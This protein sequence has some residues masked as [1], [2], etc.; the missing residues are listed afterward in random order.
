MTRPAWAC[1]N[2]L[3]FHFRA[4]ITA[5]H[6][7]TRNN[8]AT[9]CEAVARRELAARVFRARL[10]ADNL[11]GAD[12]VLT[13]RAGVAVRTR[14]SQRVGA[15]SRRDTRLPKNCSRQ[16]K[17][18]RSWL[19]VIACPLIGALLPEENWLSSSDRVGEP[20]TIRWPESAKCR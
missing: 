20:G 12:Y 14:F 18:M 19:S 16:A 7:T 11:A 5:A 1:N 3:R 2:D 6:R 4:A 9:S 10:D 17:L 15:V 13:V 8:C